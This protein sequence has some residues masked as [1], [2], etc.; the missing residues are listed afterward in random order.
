MGADRVSSQILGIGADSGST[1]GP[2]SGLWTRKTGSGSGKK[3]LLAVALCLSCLALSGLASGAPEAPEDAELRARI[4]AK[5][6]E[7]PGHEGAEVRVVVREGQV[8]LQGRVRLLEQSLR[9]EQVTWKTSGVIDVDNELRVSARGVSSDAEIEQRIRMV[10]KGDE[11][12]IDTSLQLEVKAGFVTLRGLFEDPGDVLA[13]KHRIA[14]ISG[15]LD[16]EIEAVLVAHRV[17]PDR[18]SG[19]SLAALVGPLPS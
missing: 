12:F 9:A 7:L 17:V 10:I 1:G 19:P 5:L 4:E 8:L 14:S 3:V 15:V 2:T 16:V 11:R 13:L 18:T 6:A